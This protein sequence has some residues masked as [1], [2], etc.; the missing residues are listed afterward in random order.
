ERWMT[1]TSIGE[2]LKSRVASMAVVD[3][4][5]FTLVLNQKFG[6]VEF[7]LAG[8]GA[9]IA[10]IMREADARRPASVPLLNP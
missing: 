5:T 2:Q 10:A 3:D 6:L 4:L 1:G 8:P 7:M 9:P